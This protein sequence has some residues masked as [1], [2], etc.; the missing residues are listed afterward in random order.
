MKG[1]KALRSW[2]GRQR[3]AVIAGLLG[4]PEPFPTEATAG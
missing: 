2:L 4:L 3:H 1:Y